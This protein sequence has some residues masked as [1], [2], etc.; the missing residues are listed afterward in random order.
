MKNIFFTGCP[1][2][3]HT[4]IIKYCNRPFSSVKEMNQTMI[5]NW[6]RV[7]HKEDDIYVLGDFAL[8]C[9]IDWVHD[10]LK[11]LN[12][13]KYFITGNHDRRF[14]HRSLFRDKFH[15]VKRQHIMDILGSHIL[16][17]HSKQFT[18][19]NSWNINLYCHNHAKTNEFTK[20]NGV[21]Y[22]NIG[23]D[24]NNFTPVN[25]NDIWRAK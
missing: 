25:M 18:K 19:D 1:H 7:V 22:Y 5:Q 2:F 16:L 4:N 17:T 15:F 20:I 11:T 6:N 14:I 24:G 3:N 21:L 9:T 8:C 23:M 12:G 13:E 10:L